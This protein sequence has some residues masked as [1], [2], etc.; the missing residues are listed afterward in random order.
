MT[1]PALVTV[2]AEPAVPH[3]K[4]IVPVVPV[5]TWL[6]LGTRLVEPVPQFGTR[7]AEPAEVD[8]E[9]GVRRSRVRDRSIETMT[10]LRLSIVLLLQPSTSFCQ[11]GNLRLSAATKC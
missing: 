3:E 5:V 7:I 9:I 6:T 1:V 8:P 4:I 11:Y 10:P 2:I